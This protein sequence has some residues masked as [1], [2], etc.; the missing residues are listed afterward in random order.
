MCIKEA[1][2]SSFY[3]LGHVSDYFTNPIICIHQ[4]NHLSPAQPGSYRCTQRT[5]DEYCLGCIGLGCLW[6]WCVSPRVN[7]GISL[8]EQLAQKEE[9]PSVPPTQPGY[10]HLWHWK[11]LMRMRMD[12]CEGAW[13]CFSL[14]WIPDIELTQ[15]VLFASITFYSMIKFV[16][17][18][19]N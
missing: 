5:C 15:W 12:S 16:R 19:T 4:E 3:P 10:C 8:S 6:L 2:V 13:D 14:L 11:W 17:K 9:I 1:P 18:R 7:E